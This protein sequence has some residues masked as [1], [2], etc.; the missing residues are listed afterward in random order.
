M[1]MRIRP[2]EPRD[3]PAITALLLDDAKVRE[4]LDP[5]LWAIAPDAPTRV[6][7]SLETI[8]NPITGPIRH[9]WMVAERDGIVA[10]VL[11]GAILP[12]PPIIDLQGGTAGV[13]LDDSHFTD[14]RDLSG[15]LLAAT[16]RALRDD[17]AVLF[18]AASPVHWTART[19]FLEGAGYEPT[20]LYMAKA[21]F[22]PTHPAD[23]ARIATE[24]DIDGIVRLSALHRT[25]LQKA[26]PVFWNIHREADVRFAGWMKASL[27]FPDRSMFVSGPPERIDG[28]II[29][30]PGSPLHLPAAHDATKVGLIDDF[31]AIAFEPSVESTEDAG[32]A[33]ALLFAAEGAFHAKGI[34]VALAIC[35]ARMTAK[36]SILREGGYRDANLWMV[37]AGAYS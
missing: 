28:F 34:D 8:A 3:I 33:S 22:A 36:A 9:H 21:G 14:D 15:A 16:E 2:A 6:S 27:A 19:G 31:H 10:A 23:D 1:T 29:A 13:L 24:A 12:A 18:V 11:H 17:G 5:D 30:Q 7:A 37:K 32:R 26:N 4:R 20:T 35:P 25:Q